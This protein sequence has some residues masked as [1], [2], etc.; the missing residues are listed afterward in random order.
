M[1]AGFYYRTVIMY[2]KTLFFIMTLYL[3]K[4][5]CFI[6]SLYKPYRDKTLVLSVQQSFIV[7]TIT[8]GYENTLQNVRK[9]I[10]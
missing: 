2:K 8:K 9:I 3:M 10:Y 6:Y 4:P 1:Y 5:Y 7:R